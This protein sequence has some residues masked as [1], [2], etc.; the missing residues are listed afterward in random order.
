M[1]AMTITR[2]MINFNQRLFD[3]A[4]ETTVKLQDQVEKIANTMMDK[5]NWLPG[6][7]RNVYDNCTAAYKSARTHFKTYV[8]EG[9]QQSQTLFK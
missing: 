1:D 9:Y 3:S 7:S 6:E 8:D 4:F 2:Q 5:A